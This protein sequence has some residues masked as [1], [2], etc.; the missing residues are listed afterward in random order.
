MKLFI[1]VLI[2]AKGGARD[3]KEKSH[4]ERLMCVAAFFFSPTK[5][6]RWRVHPHL[7]SLSLNYRG[8]FKSSMCAVGQH[9]STSKS[10][11]DTNGD[12]LN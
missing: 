6:N 2:R 7:L 1:K 5:R 12:V 10:K 9:K 8:G 4:W 3:L 11:K